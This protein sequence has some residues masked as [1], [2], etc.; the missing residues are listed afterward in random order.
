MVTFLY[1]MDNCYRVFV[2]MKEY[3]ITK[4]HL[5]LMLLT[6]NP[7]RRFSLK[8]LAFFLKIQQIHSVVNM[9]Y[10]LKE[11]GLELHKETINGLSYYS[12]EDR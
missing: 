3:A 8:E 5:L 9:I 10:K 12:V 11:T 7:G 4:R 1:W 6:S 2:C